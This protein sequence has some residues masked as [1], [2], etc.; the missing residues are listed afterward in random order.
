M[1]V[2]GKVQVVTRPNITGYQHIPLGYAF[3]APVGKN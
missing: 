2:Q 3:L 1:L